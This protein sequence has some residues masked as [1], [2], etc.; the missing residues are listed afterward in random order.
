MQTPFGVSRS[1]RS[2]AMHV[3]AACL[4]QAATDSS[5]FHNYKQ[6]KLAIFGLISSLPNPVKSK[7]TVC[8]RCETVR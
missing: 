5:S 1:A 6:Q 7:L 3:P 2:P 8:S 4:D